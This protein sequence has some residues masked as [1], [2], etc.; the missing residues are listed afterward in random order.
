MQ[1]LLTMDDDGSDVG[2]STLDASMSRTASPTPSNADLT[3]RSQMAMP[4]PSSSVQ[5]ALSVDETAATLNRLLNDAHSGS[6][7]VG[8]LGQTLL[9]QEAQI[10]SM[11]EQLRDSNETHALVQETQTEIAKMKAEQQRLARD[12]LQVSNIDLA[13]NDASKADVHA[14]IDSLGVQVTPELSL[15]SPTKPTSTN[16]REMRRQKNATAPNLSKDET[17]VNEIQ[18]QLINEVRRLQALIAE[19]DRALAKLSE[20]L[21]DAARIKALHEVSIKRLETE[22]DAQDANLYEI[23]RKEELLREENDEMSRQL[24]KH[25]NE[26]RV[27]KRQLAEKTDVA[28]TFK[29]TNEELEQRVEDLRGS[30][31][32]LK[33]K[34]VAD[35]KMISGLKVQVN[36]WEVKHRQVVEKI[37]PSTSIASRLSSSG[38]A[39]A[40]ATH[41]AG[42]HGN[43]VPDSPTARRLGGAHNKALTPTASVD[44]D[45]AG[46][47][48]PNEAIKNMEADVAKWRNA[49]MNYRKKWNDARRRSTTEGRTFDHDDSTDEDEDEDLWQ[50]ENALPDVKQSSIRSR[51][52]SSS[53]RRGKTMGDAFGINRQVGTHAQNKRASWQ[54][55]ELAEGDRSFNDDDASSYAASSTRGSIDGFDPHFADPTIRGG[56]GSSSASKSHSRRRSTYT[57]N[58]LAKASPLTRQLDLSED[59]RSDAGDS[60]VSHGVTGSVIHAPVG[61]LGDELLAVQ[62]QNAG[63]AYDS[64]HAAEQSYYSDAEKGDDLVETTAG[65][66]GI[67]EAEHQA[68]VEHAVAERDATHS[69]QLQAI[70]KEHDEA[71]GTRDIEHGQHIESIQK[72]HTVTLA[73]R[74]AMHAEQL[75]VVQK[76]HVEALT[77]LTQSH[78]QAMDKAM[79]RH[80]QSL[81]VREQEHESLVSGLEKRHE[82]RVK[83]LAVRHTKAH[84]EAMADARQRH[85]EALAKQRD[86]AQAVLLA[87][88][89]EHKALLDERERTYLETQRRREAQYERE[90]SNR[91]KEHQN[92]LED[93]QATHV[94]FINQ[95]DAAFNQ[96]IS[97]RDQIIQEKDD[98]LSNLHNRLVTLEAE[99][100]SMRGRVEQAE[101]KLTDTTRE[102]EQVRSALAAATAAAANVLSSS[103]HNSHEDFQDANED[104]QVVDGGKRAG[105]PSVLKLDTG[106]QTDDAM[107][108]QLQSGLAGATDAATM[109]GSSSRE[110]DNK[111]GSSIDGTGLASSSAGRLARPEDVDVTGESIEKTQDTV[112]PEGDVSRDAKPPITTVLPPMPA[113]PPP[114]TLDS[115]LAR[116]SS[117]QKSVANAAGRPKSPPPTDLVGRSQHGNASRLQVPAPN[118]GNDSRPSSRLAAGPPPSAF[119][120]TGPRRSGTP[121]TRTRTISQEGRRDPDRASVSSRSHHPMRAPSAQSFASDATSDMMSGRTSRT[122]NYNVDEDGRRS[123]NALVQRPG[124]GSGAVS[125]DPAVLG[126][127][128]QTMIGSYLYKYTRR[129]MGR[130]NKRHKRY[131]WVHPYTR[132]LYW[133]LQAPSEAV[134]TE[135]VN[136]SAFIQDVIVEEDDNPN[137]PGLFHLSI[138]VSTLARSVKMTAH[139]RDQHELWVTALGY[140]VNRE[141]PSESRPVP[142]EWRQSISRASLP[143]QSRRSVAPASSILTPARRP[144]A[145]LSPSKS[146]STFSRRNTSIDGTDNDRTPRARGASVSG[147]AT[148]LLHRKDTAA[149]EYLEQW[150]QLKANTNQAGGEAHHASRAGAISSM[151]RRSG[152]GSLAREMFG[153][154]RDVSQSPV[155]SLSNDPRLQSAEAMLAEDEERA[156]YEGLDNVRACCDGKHDVG[157][158]AHKS[159]R[160]RHSTASVR[161]R[162]STPSLLHRASRAS[163]IS[164]RS[165][166]DT[167]NSRPTSPNAPPQLGPLNINNLDAAPLAGDDA[168]VTVNGPVKGSTGS[169]EWHSASEFG[170][171]GGRATPSSDAGKATPLSYIDRITQIRRNRASTSIR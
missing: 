114:P 140:L 82:E 116:A 128:T 42:Q 161:A 112:D 65:K 99:L 132:T 136:K 17:L 155:P 52:V 151:S 61:A 43:L 111:P 150:E 69:E 157:S 34:G 67:G 130:S 156:G 170:S 50:D 30:V 102:L 24:K 46:R 57:P 105:P 159:T 163:R 87:A 141:L 101:A 73:E 109:Q 13:T 96:H 160:H 22:K 154:G 133:T 123:G 166:E 39:S 27:L 40:D 31:A 55:Q 106:S 113:M 169:S 64:Q 88:Q 4:Q 85:S 63:M 51:I 137:P 165:G 66:Q 100:N 129:T 18:Q 103:S 11:L 104:E 70:R 47:L 45:L 143:R 29:A 168:D 167:E 126:S 71:L 36:D 20:A 117:A 80:T 131:F 147:T 14:F 9:N 108:V 72:Q 25:E 94:S 119:M 32:T 2:D 62:D 138:V 171:M 142:S 7:A 127:I 16:A 44:D 12:L 79:Q 124:M 19:R 59:A 148:S 75:Q 21:D 95:R 77:Q 5:Q 23:E 54:S 149:K 135:V 37:P 41:Y 91:L 49:A 60:Y 35:Q 38:D 68:A 28:E 1:S 58:S 48:R 90:L 98:E 86:E 134:S 92:M 144:S 26:L 120:L 74:D 115:M 110:Q 56:G 84:E 6:F 162:T 93:V 118:P 145:P 146:A 53:S 33:A 97:Q 78:A 153:G 3:G 125:T 139:N 10:Q 76:D 158:L 152:R 89:H 83:E 15:A 107:W 122:S 81:A 164:D 121:S 8:A